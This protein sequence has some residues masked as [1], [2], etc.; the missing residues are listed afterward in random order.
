MTTIKLTGGS[1]GSDEMFV[2]CD[3]VRAS[4]PIQVDYDN[5]EGW[6]PTQYECA[7]AKHGIAGLE[8]IARTLGASAVE[9]PETEFECDIIEIDGT[10]IPADDDGYVATE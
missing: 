9:E 3:L 7:D 6:Q 8:K 2:R 10:E 4:A 1:F 5:G